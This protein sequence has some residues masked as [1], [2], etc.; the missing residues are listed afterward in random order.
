MT[1][2]CSKLGSGGEG[3]KSRHREGDTHSHMEKKERGRARERK[4]EIPNWGNQ[5]EVAFR[6][7]EKDQLGFSQWG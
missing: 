6:C 3:I 4:R 7:P 2:R 5:E 1:E